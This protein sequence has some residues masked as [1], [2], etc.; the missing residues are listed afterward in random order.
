MILADIIE[1]RDVPRSVRDE[2]EARNRVRK[3][4]GI[5]DKNIRADNA[6]YLRFIQAEKEA[7]ERKKRAEIEN[8]QEE[9]RKE[10]IRQMPPDMLLRYV[11]LTNWFEVEASLE[12]ADAVMTDSFG[13]AFPE[14]D[15][16][17]IWYPVVSKLDRSDLPE[18]VFMDLVHYY[19]EQKHGKSFHDWLAAMWD[20]TTA[21][22]TD[23]HHL[24]DQ[25]PWR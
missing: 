9:R 4:S 21:A 7:A 10:I 25:N 14:G 12:R 19:F 18:E 16:W 24:R 13:L 8:E 2:I 6:E 20:D 5:T 22:L 3:R 15:P 17:D 23:Y 1:A 11:K